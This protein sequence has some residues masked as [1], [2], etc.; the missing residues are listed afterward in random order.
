MLRDKKYLF[1]PYQ[2]YKYCVFYPLFGLSTVILGLLSIISAFLVNQRIASIPGIIWAR[3]NSFITPMSVRVTGEENIDKDSSYVIVANHQ[4]QYDIF[5]I[6]GWLPVDFKWVM[7]IE[8]RGIP[9]L[10]YSCYRIGHIFID[11]SNPQAAI[12]S[13]IKAKDRIRKGTSIV[14]FP[15]GHRSSDGKLLEFKKGAFA[16]ALETGFSILPVTIK[17]TGN[18]L[19]SNT[20]ALFPGKAEL[21][22][23]E[24][25]PVKGYDK[26]NIEELIMKSRESI[27]K[28]LDEK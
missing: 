11:R 7:K 17:G 19:P 3:F 23:H 5:V 28:G 14:F 15:E 8:L 4:S 26:E 10:G 16:F 18:I 6:Y 27:Q 21:I 13:I 1:Y 2:L 20:T 25:V 12:D 9:V 22:I 24:P